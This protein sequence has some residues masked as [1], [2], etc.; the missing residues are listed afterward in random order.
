MGYGQK[1]LSPEE[2]VFFAA[3][4]EAKARSWERDKEIMG[5]YPGVPLAF[6]PVRTVLILLAGLM[7]LAWIVAFL[8]L[9]SPPVQ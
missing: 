9:V 2:Q 8:Y 6:Q 4:R 1:L 3:E 5:L 7:A